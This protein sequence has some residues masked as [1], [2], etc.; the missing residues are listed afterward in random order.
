M[1]AHERAVGQ[2]SSGPG[3]LIGQA[4][5]LK[6]MGVRTKKEIPPSFVD[7]NLKDADKEEQDELS[8]DEDVTD[9]DDQLSA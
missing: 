1:G 7:A 5:K 9:H 4:E 6:A 2:L 8:F 3:N